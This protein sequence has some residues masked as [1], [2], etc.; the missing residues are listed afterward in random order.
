MTTLK[1][2]RTAFQR[3]TEFGLWVA[4]GI[5]FFALCALL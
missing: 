3:E 2:I 4:F 1:M 5:A